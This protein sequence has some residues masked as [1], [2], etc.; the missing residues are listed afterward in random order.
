MQ[1]ERERERERE[2]QTKVTG[3]F[4]IK[5]GEGSL[6]TLFNKAANINTPPYKV[7]RTQIQY[8]RTIQP[9]TRCSCE[10]FAI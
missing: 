6:A 5:R 1:R 8:N 3:L 10:V 4:L 7:T 9:I 2:R